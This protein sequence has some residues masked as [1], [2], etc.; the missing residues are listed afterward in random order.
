MNLGDSNRTAERTQEFG[1]KPAQEQVNGAH[2]DLAVAF[3]EMHILAFIFDVEPLKFLVGFRDVLD[4]HALPDF[5]P[6]VEHS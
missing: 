2:P 6:E 1:Q 5:A 4:V 3:C